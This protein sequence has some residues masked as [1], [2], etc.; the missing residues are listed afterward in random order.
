[1]SYKDLKQLKRFKKNNNN[2]KRE[3]WWFFFNYNNLK[4]KHFY[5]KKPR[6]AHFYE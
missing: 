5:V 6:A 3:C 1:M 2:M 4:N